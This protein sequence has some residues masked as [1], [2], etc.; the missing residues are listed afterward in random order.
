M[1]GHEMRAEIGD[2]APSSRP[3]PILR[4]AENAGNRDFLGFRSFQSAQ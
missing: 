2:K 1:L 4:R 3:D